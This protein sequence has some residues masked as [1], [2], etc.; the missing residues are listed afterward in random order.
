[1]CRIR[2]GRLV[3]YRSGLP[4]GISATPA[5]K[6]CPAHDIKFCADQRGNEEQFVID[7]LK[8]DATLSSFE[9]RTQIG[10]EPTWHIHPHASVRRMKCD[11]GYVFTRIIED[12]ELADYSERIHENG[13]TCMK[14]TSE[15]LSRMDAEVYENQCQFDETLGLEAFARNEKII[16]QSTSDYHNL[17][18]DNN[19]D[20]PQETR[21]SNPLSLFDELSLLD[22]SSSESQRQL[23]SVL[24]K[25]FSHWPDGRPLE[26]LFR[27]SWSLLYHEITCKGSQFDK[28]I[29]KL[30]KVCGEEGIQL[31]FEQNPQLLKGKLDSLDGFKLKGRAHNLKGIDFSGCSMKG[32]VFQSISF[33]TCKFNTEQLNSAIIE[34]GIFSGCSFEGKRFSSSILGNAHFRPESGKGNQ[35]SESTHQ[36]S[37]ILRQSCVNQHNEFSLQ[38]WLVV[39]GKSHYLRSGST[40]LDGLSRTILIRHIDEIKSFYP[41]QLPGIIRG[42]FGIEFQ[43]ITNATNFVCNNPEFYDRKIKDLKDLYFEF[44]TAFLKEGNYQRDSGNP[45]ERLFLLDPVTH[46][47][48][49]REAVLALMLNVINLVLFPESNDKY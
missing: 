4:H 3:H 17:I 40:P 34:K 24:K 38:Q 7:S 21:F 19:P 18:Q 46:N 36:L 37:R 14:L 6:F 26:Q 29:K 16:A 31:L 25:R 49:S 32:T 11:T 42:L 8:N 33:H 5:R 48:Y 2:A 47:D 13:I 45:F 35:I 1:H 43:N 15:T 28:G 10:M 41:Q 22:I 27:K 12:G 20:S 9:R 30:V 44:R 23:L 39:M